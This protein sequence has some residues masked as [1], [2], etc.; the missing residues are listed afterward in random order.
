M[1]QQSKEMK[2]LLEKYK[3]VIMEEIE[4]KSQNISVPSLDYREFRKQYISRTISFYEKSCNFSEKLIKIKPSVVQE[5]SLQEHLDVLHMEA[6]PTGVMSFSILAPVAFILIGM[7]FSVLLPMIFGTVP[8]PFFVVIF[9]FVG[10]ILMIPL[11]KIPE[12]MANSQRMKASNQMV[13][14]IFYVVTYMRHTSNLERAINFAA[15]HLSPPLSLDMKKIMWDVE[16]E[17]YESV[18]EALAVYLDGWK[19][20]NMEFV[21]AL[22]LVE[23][24]L[25]ESSE[26]R[27]IG[28]LDKAL[29]V[30][31]EETYEKML[32]YAQNLKTPITTLHMLGI[33]LPILGLVVLPLMVSFMEGVQW[34]HIAMFYNVLIPISVFYL[35]K[36]ILSSRPTGYGESDISENPEIA[37]YKN[38]L[39]K[40]GNLEI[41]LSPLF[42][43]VF[44]GVFFLF[45]GLLPII[46]HLI[47]FQ[48]ASIGGKDIKLLDYHPSSKNPEVI[49][50]PYGMGASVLSLFVVLALGISFGLYYKL[51]SENVIRIRDESKNLEK[52]FAAALFQ[53]G[54]RLG[55]NIPAELA[56]S[57]VASVMEGTTAGN[58]FRMVSV[59]ITRLGMSVEKAIFDSRIGALVYFPS[60]LIESTMKVLIES[61][62]KGPMI[63]SQALISVSEYIKEIHRVDERLKDLLADVISSMKS[64]IS[65]LT[66]VIAGIVVGITSMIT[67]ILGKLGTQIQTISQAGAGAGTQA[68]LGGAGLIGLFGEG[69]PTYFF[70]IVVGI[71]V[72]QIV[73]ILTILTNGIENG[74]DKLSERYQLG[75][76][77]MRSTILYCIVSFAVMIVF[78]LIALSIMS[79]IVS[80]T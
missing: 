63:A 51:R 29:S 75:T 76:N 34:Y 24:S 65:F 37:K 62:K 41:Q 27:R 48:D 19:K 22:N 8:D 43:A 54:N 64:Q 18:K 31:L 52:E 73:F 13:L 67:T 79:G 40:I 58:F 39:L 55:D 71:Y 14:C 59:N 21:E 61:S 60:N 20:Y 10:L 4:G 69:I 80:P 6:T 11:S 26:E 42:V 15:E 23:S 35:G 46:L 45:I 30:M 66:P 74:E 36:K 3:K 7:F 77:L 68:G 44:I 56:F 25:Y 33:I 47:N 49:V 1:P 12:F 50:G 28:A 70:Q 17:K 32:H 16:T 53:L 78:N 57:K 9:L 5:K 38:I 72:V 2:D